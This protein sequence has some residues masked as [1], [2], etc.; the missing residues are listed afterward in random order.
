M[1]SRFRHEELRR[2]WT[3]PDGLGRSRHREIRLTQDGKGLVMAAIFLTGG[4]LVAA[5]ILSA[6]IAVQTREARLLREEGVVTEGQITRLWRDRDK[7]RQ[8][9]L[10]YT[11]T[12]QERA[13][14]RTAK[15][16]LRLWTSLR[17]GSTLAVRYVPSDPE[18]SVPFDRERDVLP[19]WLPIAV[20]FGLGPIGFLIILP[21]RKQRRLL[22]EGRVAPGLVT[23]Q[24]KLRRGSHGKALGSRIDYEFS[25]LSGAVA[26]GH[27]GPVKNPPEVGSV[28]PVLYE[29]EEPA[30]NTVYPLQLVRLA[31]MCK[32]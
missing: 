15:V 25:L 30:Q 14:E 8:P 28:I 3:P 13:Y 11:Y 31:R 18:I 5:I 24:G 2:I 1:T 21:L 27:A 17:V 19:L 7:S 32:S 26:R 20:V 12:S 22:S 16:S 23:H 9:R 10:A 6:V 4:A 29:A